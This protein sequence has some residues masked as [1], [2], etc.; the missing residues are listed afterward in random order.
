MKR[1]L[2]LALLSLGTTFCLHR[3]QT[4]LAPK[5]KTSTKELIANKTYEQIK[6]APLSPSQVAQLMKDPE[7]TNN[8]II[9]NIVILSSLHGDAQ[10]AFAER[11]LEKDPDILLR[12]YQMLAILKNQ[13]KQSFHE[14]LYPQTSL[15]KLQSIL[16]TDKTGD[17][18]MEA[19]QYEARSKLAKKL[20]CTPGSLEDGTCQPLQPFK[21]KPYFA[22]KNWLEI[23]TGFTYYE[24]LSAGDVPI[25]TNQQILII[26]SR[27]A[28]H[29]DFDLNV[30]KKQLKFK[31]TLNALVKYTQAYLN[32][33]RGEILYLETNSWAGWLQ[34]SLTVKFPAE[35]NPVAIS[36]EFNKDYLLID[37][38]NAHIGVGPRY[39]IH[40]SSLLDFLPESIAC[41]IVDNLKISLVLEYAKLIKLKSIAIPDYIVKHT[42]N[43]RK[44][45]LLQAGF[46]EKR[47][48]FWSS[49]ELV[50]DVKAA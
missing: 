46:K 35:E 10:I 6:Q 1:L 26:L 3:P 34:L 31:E 43:C 5:L 17:N 28:Q 2:I 22:K 9:K 50:Y 42:S 24:K 38:F 49:T 33:E 32:R 44:E 8:P 16:F 40:D 20:N 41:N 15:E 4:L 23:L 7:I 11:I 30:L 25:K 27:S 36:F 47:K 39:S 45:L 14:P 18:I 37:S 29:T 19:I 21:D 13:H 12:I 48:H